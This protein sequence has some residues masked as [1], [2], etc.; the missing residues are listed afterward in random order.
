M[1]TRARSSI[2]LMAILYGRAEPFVQF[3]EGHYEEHW[4]EFFFEFGRVVQLSFGWALT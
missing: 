4:S 3:S 1:S 2:A